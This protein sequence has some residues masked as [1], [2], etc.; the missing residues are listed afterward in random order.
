MT[1]KM[2]AK[3]TAALL[4]EWGVTC[5][6]LATFEREWPE[7]AEITAKNVARA[8]ALGLDVDWA[9]RCAVANNSL[10]AAEFLRA[11]GTL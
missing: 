11:K 6:Q 4:R 8:R 9:L 7:G 10:A 1:A 2:P 3:I 5:S